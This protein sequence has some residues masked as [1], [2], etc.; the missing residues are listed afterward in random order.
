MEEYVPRGAYSSFFCREYAVAYSFKNHRM[1]GNA[2]KH[3]FCYGV[4]IGVVYKPICLHTMYILQFRHRIQT[5]AVLYLK[6]Y[7]EYGEYANLKKM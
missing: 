3:L 7:E 5:D 4:L 6:E 2:L 1:Q